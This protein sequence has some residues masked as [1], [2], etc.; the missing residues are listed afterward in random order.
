M[1]NELTIQQPAELLS[2]FYPHIAELLEEGAVKFNWKG[3]QLRISR[4][5]LI[6]YQQQKRMTSEQAMS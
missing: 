5:D 2:V 4:S 3:E 1:S 6:I